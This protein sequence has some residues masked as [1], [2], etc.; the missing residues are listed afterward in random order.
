MQ[1]EATGSIGKPLVIDSADS[2]SHSITEA[3][4]STHSDEHTP[5]RPGLCCRANE[6]AVDIRPAWRE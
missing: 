5:P 4:R 6:N 2:F 3:G 1:L